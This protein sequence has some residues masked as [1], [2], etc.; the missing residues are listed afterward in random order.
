MAETTLPCG[1]VATE[2]PAWMTWFVDL[3]YFTLKEAQACLFAGLFFVS[4]FLVP[5]AG[6]WGIPR[7]DVLL[8]IAVGIQIWMVWSGRETWDELKAICLFHILGFMLEL[9]K[10]SSGIRSWSYPEFA[11]TK[12]GGVPLFSGFMY[13]AVGSYIIQAWRL[14]QLRI[15]HHPP[16]WMAGLM[17]MAIYAN[18]FTHHFIGDYRWYLAAGAMGLYARTTVIFRPHLIDRRMPLPLSFLLI[19]FFIWLAENI[20]TF[21]GLWAYPHQLGAWATVHVSKWSAWSLLVLMS[22]TI[23]TNLKHIKQ[24]ISVPE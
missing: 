21:C 20:S 6:V 16:Y 9:F 4:V 8:L 19:G 23:V 24:T 22:F 5:R 15:I 1:N 12:I 18:F 2:S 3:W 17:A 7:Y 10:T 13:A 14:F 11:Y